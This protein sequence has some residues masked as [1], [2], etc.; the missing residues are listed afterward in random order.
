M[1]PIS[2]AL[3]GTLPNGSSSS[4]MTDALLNALPTRPPSLAMTVALL[5]EVRL[6]CAL[7]TELPFSY[8]YSS[9]KP[10]TQRGKKKGRLHHRSSSS[11]KFQFSWFAHT[12]DHVPTDAGAYA[13]YAPQDNSHDAWYH[14]PRYLWIF[15]HQSSC[16]TVVGI[17]RVHFLLDIE[18]S[19][20]YTMQE[21]AIH[22]LS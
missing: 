6:L 17:I 3:L 7:L 4:V 12:R 20:M 2:D 19:L 11:A 8:S 15:D 21:Q 18:D 5:D 1:G 16:I 22:T 10:G 14:T 9:R 13:I